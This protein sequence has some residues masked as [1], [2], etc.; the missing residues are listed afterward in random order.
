MDE[1]VAAL[2]EDKPAL[3]TYNLKDCRAGRAFSRNQDHAVFNGR[4]TINGLPVDR[5]GV[6]VAAFEYF[7]PANAP[8]PAMSRPISA[9]CRRWQV[10]AAVMD[11]EKRLYGDSVLWCWIIKPVPVDYR[12]FLKLI[13]QRA[14]RGMARPGSGTQCRRF[15]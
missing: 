15:P 7:A 11:S 1:I 13:R 5:H 8:A 6:P 10:P 14:G 2:P 12:T 9:K 4:A 3:A